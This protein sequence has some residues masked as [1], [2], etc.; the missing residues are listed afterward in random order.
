MTALD[1]AFLVHEKINR[2]KMDVFAKIC[3]T[4]KIRFIK[5]KGLTIAYDYLDDLWGKELLYLSKLMENEEKIYK[6][7]TKNNR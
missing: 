6:E 2:L 3:E 5:R 4:P 1:Y 7:I